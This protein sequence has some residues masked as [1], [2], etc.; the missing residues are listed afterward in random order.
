M[1]SACLT[2]SYPSIWPIIYSNPNLVAA[3]GVARLQITT[4]PRNMCSSNL[5]LL[6]CMQTQLP[7]LAKKI[8]ISR[9][10]F[11]EYDAAARPADCV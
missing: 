5:P 1:A 4:Q 3:W 8:Q 10:H 9:M 2:L 7:K 11:V 6:R